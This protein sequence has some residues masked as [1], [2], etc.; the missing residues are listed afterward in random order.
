MF[1]WSKAKK[2]AKHKLLASKAVVG[3][4]G[5]LVENA[6]CMVLETIVIGSTSYIVKEFV[7]PWTLTDVLFVDIG[8]N[9]AYILF[10]MPLVRPHFHKLF[11]KPCQKIGRKILGLDIR[12]PWA[13]LKL[14][15]SIL[16]VIMTVLLILFHSIEDIASFARLICFET[17]AIQLSVD[18][19]NLHGDK[20][21][22]YVVMNLEPN[23]Q[24]QIFKEEK[25]TPK[26][27]Q[28]HLPIS[29]KTSKTSG[30]S[31]LLNATVY[32]D[33]MF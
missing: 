6:V 16:I 25:E 31:N 23:P 33:Y 5:Q 22:D 7:S 20:I 4:V 32:K 30:T 19:W 18:L 10:A 13:F 17:F 28:P 2:Y 14:K 12:D 11:K 1:F 8:F 15:Y 3:L 24:V 21:Q 9:V 27:L 26:P 29:P